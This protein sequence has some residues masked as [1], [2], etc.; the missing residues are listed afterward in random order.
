MSQQFRELLKK[1]GSGQHTT[2]D[3]SREEAATAMKLMLEQTATPAQIGAF[4]IAHRIKRPTG[5]ELAGMLDTYDQL[6]PSLA[7]LPDHF[8]P[9]T[10]FG[11]PYD[12]RSRTAPITPITALILATA[13]IPTLMHGGDMMPTKYGIPLIDIW[14]GLGLDLKQLSLD[15]ARE[16]LI[17]TGFTFIYTPKHFPQTQDLIAYR[18]QIGKRPPLA[19]LELIWSPY[20][21]KSFLIAGYVHPPTETMIREAFQLRGQDHYLLVK[22]LEGSCDL[23]LSQT[24]IVSVNSLD[25]DTGFS[26]LKLSA[27][28][29]NLASH[30]V[31]LVSKEDLLSQTLAVLQGQETELMSGA[32]WNGGFYLWRCGVCPDLTTGLTQTRDLLLNGKV[33]SKYEQIKDYLQK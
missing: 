24:T 26:Y 13:G 17:N 27:R 18:D 12:G 3:L 6:G 28:E 25:A 8:P 2:K 20:R 21:G 23:R 14:S 22:G 15:E 29:Y 19:T 9:V 31:P 33:A 16:L 30:E 11:V 32:V 7:P 4:L 5:A 10:V 1:V